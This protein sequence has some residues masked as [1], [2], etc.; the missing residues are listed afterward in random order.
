MKLYSALYRDFTPLDTYYP[1]FEKVHAK[2]DT[3]LEA[4]GI[5]ILWGGGDIHPS[6]YNRSNQGTYAGTSPSIRD[7]DEAALFAKAQ[8]AGLFILGVCR[9]AQLGC[10]LSGGILIQDVGGHGSSHRVT[11]HDGEQFMA[12]SLHHQMMYPFDIEHKLLAWSSSPRSPDYKGI[13][14]DEW[15]RWP[16]IMYEELK[17]ED[18]IEPEMVWFPTTKCLAV[19]SH[20]EMMNPQCAHNLYIKK[21]IDELYLHQF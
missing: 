7:Q 10:A 15:K 4:P 12:S 14:E 8:K 20:P 5:L 17:S 9:G 11:T 6:F 1:T 21:C 16:R 19:Q 2:R 18:V 13:S 3:E